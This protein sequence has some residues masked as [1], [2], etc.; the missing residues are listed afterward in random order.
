MKRVLYLHTTPLAALV[1]LERVCSLSPQG[2]TAY[3]DSLPA[4]AHRAG[5]LDAGQDKDGHHVF[6]LWYRARLKVLQ[7]F[8]ESL[9]GLLLDHPDVK[10]TAVEYPHSGAAAG[11][12]LYRIGLR[13]AGR[14]SLCLSLPRRQ[15]AAERPPE[16]TPASCGCIIGA[17]C[18]YGTEKAD[19]KRRPS[20]Q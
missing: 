15:K 8:V 13:L 14:L 1:A 18:S 9:L 7:R 2:W 11:L 10:V 4:E 20:R 12:F 6:A 16:L 17:E 5:F 19:Q 3:L